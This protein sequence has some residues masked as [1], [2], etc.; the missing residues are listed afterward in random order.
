[1][2]IILTLLIILVSSNIFSAN[3]TEQDKL[4]TTNKLI[5]KYGINSFMGYVISQE[6]SQYPLKKNILDTITS[7][8]YIKR[9]K[10]K[11][12]KHILNPEWRKIISNNAKISISEVDKHIHNLM[13]KQS[14]NSLCS[15]KLNII[16][17]KNGVKILNIYSE[18]NGTKL[19]ITEVKLSNCNAL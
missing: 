4:A 3:I 18:V 5:K 12:Y 8:Y 7:V 2:R 10:A 9:T 16:Y 6:Q 1:M 11:V 19:F 15:Y 17:F 14:V 13:Q